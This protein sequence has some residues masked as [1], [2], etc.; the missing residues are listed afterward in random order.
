MRRSACAIG[1]VSPAEIAV[2]ILGEITARLR[3][4]PAKRRRRHEIRPRRRRPTR[5]APPRVHSI[6]QGELVL[7]KGTLIGPAEVA[8][9]EGRGRQGNRGGAAR[10]GRRLGGS[11]GRRYRRRRRGRGRARRPRLHRP[12]QSV[13]RDRRRAGARQ[14]RDRPPQPHRRGDDDRDAA[15][16][17]AGGGRRDDRH[18][19]DHSVRGRRRGARPGGGRGGKAKPVIRVAPYRSRKIGL[20]STLLPGLAPKVV[21]KTLK[22]TATA[23]CAGRRDASSPS[24]ACRT[25]RRRWRAPSTRCARPAPSWSIVFGASAI[26]DRRDV[27]PAAIEAVGGEIE[28]FGMPVD[29]GNLMLIGALARAG[30]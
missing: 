1:A 14:G 28:H 12:L 29:P 24:G 18:R 8:A 26:A 27:I 6:R 7:K 15:G 25:R 21:D 20:V 11:G 19:E 3:M 13:R 16:V 23:P 17:Q 30:R 5:S 22:I 2:A 10:A 9:L 4:K